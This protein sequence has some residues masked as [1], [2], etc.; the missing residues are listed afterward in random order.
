[1]LYIFIIFITLG[2]SDVTKIIS[3]EEAANL[4]L[5]EKTLNVPILNQ[6]DDAPDEGYCGESSI[7][8]VLAY[9]GVYKTQKEINKAGNPKHPDLYSNELVPAIENV[10]NKEY[11]G[12]EM[13]FY[14][15]HAI[16]YI[17]REIDN[18]NPLIVMFKLNP[19]KNAHWWADHVS[20]VNGY[21]EN[22][23]YILT[24]WDEN[25]RIYRTFEQL[26]AYDLYTEDRYE[27]YSFQNIDPQWDKWSLNV[28]IIAITKN[29]SNWNR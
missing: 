16:N 15:N 25:P 5:N 12:Y 11:N 13:K 19:S 10:T 14:D 17:R 1:M 27:G 22:G 7:Q 9:K 24:T 4:S 28:F 29:N 23:L 21:D 6:I 26:S 20:V 18:N 3:Y 2:L 8:M